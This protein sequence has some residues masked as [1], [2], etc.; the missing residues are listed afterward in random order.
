M[1]GIQ[2]AHD[3]ADCSTNL[4]I[5][6]SGS[7]SVASLYH[8]SYEG[9]VQSSVQRNPKV[10]R[11]LNPVQGWTFSSGFIATVEVAQV[12]HFTACDDQNIPYPKYDIWYFLYS[13]FSL[14]PLQFLKCRSWSVG[15]DGQK[16]GIN[17][18]DVVNITVHG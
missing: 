1:K 9:S 6:T 17:C 8:I 11:S 4:A 5:K 12:A 14:S 18:L 2:T 15:M 10:M 3:R 16:F 7:W 13:P